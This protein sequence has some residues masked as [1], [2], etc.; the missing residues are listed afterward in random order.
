MWASEP[1]TRM[2]WNATGANV[3]GAPTT[4]GKWLTCVDQATG[5]LAVIETATTKLRRLTSKG[6]GAAKEFAYFSVA[7]RDA[8]QVAYAWFNEAGFYDLRVMKMAGGGSRVL[9]RNEEAGFVQPSSWTPDGKQILTLFFRKDNIS[10]IALVDAESGA[11]RVLKSLNWVYPKKMEIS[12]DGKWIVYDS[13]AGDNPGPR[14][15]YALSIDGARETKLVEGPAED[16]FPAWSPDGKEI[17]FA[18]DRAGTMDVWTVRVS[19]G[20]PASEP[21][22]VKRDLKQFLPMGVTAAGDL[23]Y[24][25]RVGITDVAVIQ[26]GGMPSVLQTRTPG[27]N[28]A[29]A[30]SRDGKKL[31]YL[32]RRGAENFGV[33]ARVI[34]V[35]DME[36]ATEHDLEAKLAHVESLRWSPDGQ[37]LLAAGSDGKGRSGLFRLRVRDGVLAAVTVDENADYRGTPGDWLPDGTVAAGAGA[38]AVAVSD[39]GRVARAYDDKVTVED[40]NWPIHGVTWLQWAGDRLLASQAGKAVE[41][42]PEG[43]RELLWKNYSGGPFSMRADGTVAIGVGGTRHEVWVMEHVFPPLDNKR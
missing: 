4:D 38:R 22:L 27:R 19:D 8:R 35:R 41:L 24:G 1:N 12:P 5:D 31:A 20:Q 40:S 10:Q 28:L 3:L 21:R 13:F 30:W 32:S 37:W 7:S 6:P 23:Y 34:V 9:F 26:K 39:V 25:L 15:I 2:V 18:S 36:A 14:D 11:V 17:V 16:L 43:P 29:P 42:G 33:E